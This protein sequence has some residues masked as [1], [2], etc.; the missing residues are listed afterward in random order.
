M[1]KSINAEK[2]KKGLTDRYKG[3]FDVTNIGMAVYSA[4][5]DGTD[6]IF[7][8]L[9]NTFEK[10]ERVERQSVI[11]KS[12]TEIFPSVKK[13]RFFN[14]LQRVWETGHGTRNRE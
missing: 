3:I 10:I 11:G 8:N 7:E 9:N 1:T 13:F 12:I 4:N 5:R 14:A 2:G 6:F